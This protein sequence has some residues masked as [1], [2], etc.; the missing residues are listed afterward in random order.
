MWHCVTGHA[1]P[2]VS[3]DHNAFIFMVQLMLEVQALQSLKTS[4]T[5]HSTIQLHAPVYLNLQQHQCDPQI[6]LKLPNFAFSLSVSVLWHVLVSSTFLS[7]CLP[8]FII[9]IKL[10]CLRWVVNMAC[11]GEIRHPHRMLVR[12]P[13]G[14]SL[15]R[16]R[17][18]WEGIKID[19][20]ETVCKEVEW[21]HLAQGSDH[22]LSVRCIQ[23]PGF[24]I[25]S[26]ILWSPCTIEL[27]GN[28]AEMYINVAARHFL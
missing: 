28:T 1:V 25:D 13:A 7:Y 4:G 22:L 27:V 15:V 23:T 18:K 8:S 24:H 10:R 16:P 21:I 26:G 19:L 11:I 9:I 17:Q 20:R 2:V 14:R 5:A 3:N 6:L 12:R